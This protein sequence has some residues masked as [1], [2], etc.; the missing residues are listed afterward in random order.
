MGDFNLSLHPG[1]VFSRPGSWGRKV[2]EGEVGFDTFRMQYCVFVLPVGRANCS[3]HW[4]VESSALSSL[5]D[6]NR[7]TVKFILDATSSMTA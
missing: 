3:C 4:L 5:A 1:L 6:A 7:L 2:M